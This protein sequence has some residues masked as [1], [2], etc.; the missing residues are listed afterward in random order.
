MAPGRGQWVFGDT[1]FSERMIPVRIYCTEPQIEAIADITAKF[2][3]QLAVMYYLI[4]NQVVIKEYPN[5][6]RS[7]ES[8]GSCP[9]PSS[10]L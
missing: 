4:S 2:Y 9:R 1:L 10:N 8:S 5:E 7:S 6:S 3:E